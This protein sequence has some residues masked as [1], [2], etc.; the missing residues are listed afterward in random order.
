T[1][2]KLLAEVPVIVLEVEDLQPG[3]VELRGVGEDVADKGLARI[4]SRMRLAGK[5]NL[6][7]AEGFGNLKQTFGVVE[8]QRGALVRSDATR[9]AECEHVRIEVNAGALLHCGEEAL[10]T[11]L[12]RRFYAL[13]I[14]TV[15]RAEV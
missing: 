2:G 13:R 9:E 3:V 14:E 11:E 15:D 8:E 10:L 1:I 5:E 12:V 4:V 6:Q 7:A